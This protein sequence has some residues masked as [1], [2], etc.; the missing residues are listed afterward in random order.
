[1]TS[2]QHSIDPHPIIPDPADNDI[3]H[4]CP[5]ALAYSVDFSWN[6]PKLF[7]FLQLLTGVPTGDVAYTEVKNIGKLHIRPAPADAEDDILVKAA[8][9]GNSHAVLKEFSFERN[10]ESVGI[11]IPNAVPTFDSGIRPCIYL[12]VTL[13]I[14]PSVS[15]SLFHTQTQTLDTILYPGLEF[16]TPD[17]SIL[18]VANSIESISSPSSPHNSSFTGSRSIVIRTH[19]GAITGTYPLYD[20]LKLVS[21]SGSITAFVIPKSADPHRR[22]PAFLWVDSGSGSVRLN[23]PVLSSLNSSSSSSSSSSPDQSPLEADIPDRDYQ[24]TIESHSG[25]ITAQL[26]HGSRTDITSQSGH[27]QTDLTPYGDPN[28]RSYI[29]I[30]TESGSIDTRVRGSASD[31]EAALRRLFV[32]FEY[33]T[34]SLTSRMPPAWEGKIRGKLLTGEANILWQGMQID[35]YEREGP[36]WRSDSEED[37]D[38]GAGND[39]YAEYPKGGW[40][41]IDGKGD[42]ED[43]TKLAEV[44]TGSGDVHSEG[45]GWKIL[46]GHKGR[47]EGIFK[48]ESVTG[49]ATLAG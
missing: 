5:S 6:D 46:E 15:L 33:S 20:D 30:E 27:V 10:D 44:E 47:G 24:T 13:W 43:N 37:D 38:G 36:P 22:R 34:G 19:S 45:W 4:S 8:I 16:A 28:R 21:R 9:H 11:Y 25:S 2:D 49:S 35:R 14:K 26:L 3:P 17:L 1:M 39:P 31:P 48:F 41:E 18:T 7:R 42:E 40:H 12:N 23:T 29:K 32:T